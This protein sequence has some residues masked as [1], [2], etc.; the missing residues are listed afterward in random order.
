MKKMKLIVYLSMFLFVAHNTN[1]QYSHCVLKKKLDAGYYHLSPN[2]PLIFKFSEEYTKQSG[3]L[4]YK[5]YTDNR[6]L[7][8]TCNPSLNAKMGD[9]R[10]TLN[11][12]GCGLTTNTI[13]IIE[14][15]N[16]KNEKWL[17]RFKYNIY[18][19]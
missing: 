9:N 6:T 14:V 4:T 18:N 3:T 12:S 13:Y 15:Y 16:E 17:A 11:L 5:I 1:A 8:S 7:I 10:F 19:P 2:G